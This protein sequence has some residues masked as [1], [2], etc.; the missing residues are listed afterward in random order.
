MIKWLSGIVALVLLTSVVAK[1]AEP[2]GLELRRRSTIGALGVVRGV[3]LT[4]KLA[5]DGSTLATFNAPEAGS[6]VLLFTSGR[7]TGKVAMTVRVAKPGPVTAKLR[8]RGR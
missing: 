4:T 2:V 5:P 8:P 3:Q 6:Y 7:E 1:G